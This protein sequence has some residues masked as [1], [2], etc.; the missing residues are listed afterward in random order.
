MRASDIKIGR[1]YNVIFDPVK[2]CEFDGKHLAVV[3]KKNNDKSTFIV[4][5]LTSS[6]NGSSINKILLG[7]IESLPSSL[8][9]NDTYAVFNQVRTVNASRFISLKEGSTVIEARLE[10]DKFYRLLVLAIKE[11]LYSIDQDSKILLLR[12]AYEQECLEKAK[13]IAYRIMALKRSSDDRS[14]EIEGLRKQIK[15]ILSS[16][17]YS[18]KQKYPVAGVDAIFKQSLRL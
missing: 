16:I 11:L 5:P 8:K 7:K 4:M 13:D 3:L 17:S 12:I 9:N 1:I 2:P 10:Q 15:S 6:G 14:S 18:L